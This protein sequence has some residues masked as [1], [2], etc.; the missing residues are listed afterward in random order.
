MSEVLKV[1]LLL[2][3]SLSLV[4]LSLAFS[5]IKALLKGEQK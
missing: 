3:I 1:I 5:S 4:I 2:N